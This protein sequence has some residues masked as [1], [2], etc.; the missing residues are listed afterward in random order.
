MYTEKPTFFR[1]QPPIKSIKRRNLLIAYLLGLTDVE[2]K[3]K[4]GKL[5]KMAN[6]IDIIGEEFT[7]SRYKAAIAEKIFFNK[8][9]NRRTIL[10]RVL[11][12][13]KDW[14]F[15]LAKTDIINEIGELNLS[16]KAKKFLIVNIDKVKDDLNS[17]SPDEKLKE[18]IDWF[19]EPRIPDEIKKTRLDSEQLTHYYQIK[20]LNFV[21]LRKFY[22][23]KEFYDFTL[24]LYQLR[25]KS[26]SF[27]GLFNT[28]LLHIMYSTMTILTSNKLEIKEMGIPPL[29]LWKSFGDTFDEGYL[30]A[31]G[32]FTFDQVKNLSS[33]MESLSHKRLKNIFI[34]CNEYFTSLLKE[35][36]NTKIPQTINTFSIT[37]DS[38][39]FLQKLKE[40]N[41]WSKIF[42]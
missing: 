1:G 31:F 6:R 42:Q 8:K 27:A 17:Q 3:I 24:E 30:F 38:L 21:E 36:I 15:E 32:A 34:K 23:F 25:D 33:R 7:T 9:G 16:K 22:L 14:F 5:K 41:D 18:C 2:F 11:D 4:V 10:N 12:K 29:L 39:K 13:N 20:E 26:I 37:D 35:N 28:Y 40:A 19:F